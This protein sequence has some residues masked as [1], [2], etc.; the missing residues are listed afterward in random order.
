MVS[1]PY[2]S[3]PTPVVR[4]IVP[5]STGRVLILR[6]RNTSSGMGSWCLPC[7]KVDYGN[8]I[9]ETIRKELQEETSLACTDWRFLFWQDSLPTPGAPMHCINLYFECAVSGTVTLDDESSEYAWISPSEL[10]QY[11]I[12]FRSDVAILR[13][14]KEWKIK[15]PN[16]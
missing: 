9:E 2:I 1:L 5:D 10:S 13:Y 3:Y 6:R 4:I 12:V 14:W 7:G 11:Q 15:S 16:Q 8:T